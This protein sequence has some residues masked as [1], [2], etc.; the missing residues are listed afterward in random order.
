AELRRFRSRFE[1]PEEYAR[2]LATSDLAE[3]EL[4]ATLSRTMRVQRFVERRVGQAVRVSDAEV[5]DY[6]RSRGVQGGTS[7]ARDAVRAH[8]AEQRLSAE[9]KKIVGE[10]RARATVRILFPPSEVL[11]D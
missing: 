10:L 2:F 9:V 5:D 11:S 8:L 3:E 4:L 6:L 7:A 1:S